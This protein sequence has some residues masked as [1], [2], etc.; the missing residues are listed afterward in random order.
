MSEYITHIAVL[1]DTRRMVPFMKQIHPAFNEALQKHPLSARLGSGSRGNHLFVPD[2]LE[3]FGKRWESR[4]KEE[5]LEEKLA[6]TIGWISHRGA[7]VHFKAIYKQLD[8]NEA[9][10]PVD[11]RIV[12]D[13][14][15]FNT[16]YQNGENQPLHPSLLEQRLAGHPAAT[17]MDVE[18]VENIVS[19]DHQ[20]QLLSLQ[21]ES[22]AD[23]TMEEWVKWFEDT[24]QDYYVEIPRYTAH[25]Y[26]PNYEQLNRFIYT[27]DFYNPED[28]IIQLVTDMRDKGETSV[29][30]SVAI[31]KAKDQSQYSHALYKCYLYLMAADALFKSQIDKAEFGKRFEL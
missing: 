24:F 11:I 2:F 10:R 4:K 5:R 21:A 30:F 16:V 13:I 29:D 18:Q 19:A 23:G 12:H 25:Y 27:P 1:D 7:D 8:K 28:E 6:F 22:E 31:R 26:D 15:T 17:I 9:L 20:L 3:K 14:I